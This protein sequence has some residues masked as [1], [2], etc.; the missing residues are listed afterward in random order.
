MLRRDEIDVVCIPHLLQ[1][2]VPLGELLRRQVESLCLVGNV[3]VLAEYAT[4]VAAG[5]EDRAGS[6]VALY[7]GLYDISAGCSIS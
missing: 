6:V 3:M 7:T 1:L 4:E 2:N 5:E